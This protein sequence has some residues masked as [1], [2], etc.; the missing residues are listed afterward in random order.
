MT[1]KRIG[2]DSAG[3]VRVEGLTVGSPGAQSNV[4]LVGD[5]EECVVIDPF[6]GADAGALAQVLQA[7]G[8]RRLTAALF[9]HSPLGARTA[10]PEMLEE[11]PRVRIGVHPA[12]AAAWTEANGGVEPNLALQEGDIVTVGDIE[13]TVLHTPGRTPGSCCFH[14]GDVSV[15]FSG[16]T[17]VREVERLRE[18]DTATLVL[19]ACGEVSTLG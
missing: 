17:E 9:T 4:W 7:V 18:L 19:P 3:G 11:R 5:D 16:Q 15:L 2:P 6:I 8:D 10:G 14:A 12:D 13:L 1:M